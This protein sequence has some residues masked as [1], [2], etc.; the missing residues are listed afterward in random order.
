MMNQFP[1]MSGE[2]SMRH[3][4]LLENESGVTAHMHPDD[5]AAVK[6]AAEK[7]MSGEFSGRAI[8]ACVIAEIVTPAYLTR[9]ERN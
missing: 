3:L 8:V 9:A 7:M 6:F 1:N 4:V 2:G 5:G